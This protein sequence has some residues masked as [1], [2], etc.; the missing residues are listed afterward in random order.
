MS[1]IAFLSISNKVSTHSY[2]LYTMNNS[3]DWIWRGIYALEILLL[4]AFTLCLL[5]GLNKLD[6]LQWTEIGQFRSTDD[7]R[8]H[9]QLQI[10]AD[11]KHQCVLKHVL[12]KCFQ[13]TFGQI[14]NQNDRSLLILEWSL[15]DIS[16]NRKHCCQHKPVKSSRQSQDLINKGKT[17]NIDH[18]LQRFMI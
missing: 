12:K 11:T 16:K 1:K 6:L 13:I 4:P 3:E 8:L 2:L 17:R 7:T 9:Q 5:V 15:Q 10:L 14:W 18:S